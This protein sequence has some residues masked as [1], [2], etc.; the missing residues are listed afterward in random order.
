M[1]HVPLAAAVLIVI[2]LL[3]GSARVTAAQESTPGA[4]PRTPDP[5][6]CQVEPRSLD[7]MLSLTGTPVAGTPAADEALEEE[8]VLPAS[9]IAGLPIQG[10]PADEATVAAIE[11]T[12][13]EV[14]ACFNAGD[15][16]RAFALF[17]DDLI[18]TFGPIPEE[19][20][21]F[22]EATPVAVAE[23][24]QLTLVDISEV[25]TLDDGRVSAVV[26]VDDPTTPVEGGEAALIVFVQQDDRWLIDEFIEI[27][28]VGT[29]A[30][31][32]PAA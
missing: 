28:A 4:L 16:L 27:P 13:N 21:P 15:F 30:A 12:V 2:A 20:I 26:I 7:D 6:E 25:R 1:R 19:E 23:E 24:E 5:A 18:G 17:S 22:I 9:P 14:L 10:E 11:E 31:G 8:A 29:P 3:T 32:T